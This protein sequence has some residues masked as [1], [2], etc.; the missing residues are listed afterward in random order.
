M[1]VFSGNLDIRDQ[2]RH[3]GLVA[4]TSV[5]AALLCSLHL[6]GQ[7]ASS[8]ALY[9]QA[10]HAL[11]AGHTEQAIKLYQELLRH[12]PDSIDARINLGVAFAQEGHYDEA[13]QQYNKALARDPEN[14]VGLLNLGLAFYKEGDLS[15][16]HDQFE[17]L[18]E[19]HPA[20]QQVFYL[21]ADCDLR[22]GRFK[23]AIALVEPAYEA[24]PDDQT[25]DYILGNALIQDGQTKNGA[26]VIDHIMRKGNPAVADVLIGTAQFAARNY[27]AAVVTLKKA[28]DLNPNIP[29]AWTV[30]GRTLLGAGKVQR[31]K[32]CSHN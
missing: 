2:L 5:V 6:A 26:A 1:L 28:L 17:K 20:N 16:A 9:D 3:L 18:H 7:Q 29:G 31:A 12:T 23:D 4:A 11:D 30:Y 15:R 19:L 27:K 32:E 21:L 22:L 24:H 13:V 25:V 8:Q 10:G 14:N